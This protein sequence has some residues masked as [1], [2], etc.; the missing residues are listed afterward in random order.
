MQHRI[1]HH[2]IIVTVQHFSYEKKI[3]FFTVGKAPQPA[4]KIIIQTISH[5]QAESVNIKI[6]DP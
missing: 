2:L 3:L 6:V 4:H 5:I 1:I